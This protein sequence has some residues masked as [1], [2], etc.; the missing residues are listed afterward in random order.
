MDNKNQLFILA[1]NGSY[2]NRGCEGI[3]RGTVHILR[4]HFDDPRF[5]AVSSYKNEEQFKQQCLKETDT[6][7][8]HKKMWGPYKRLDLNWFLLQSLQVICPKA[9]KHITYKHLKPHLDEAKAVLALGGDHYSLYGT[10]LPRACTDLDDLVVAKGK[11]LVIWGAS[12][13]PFS[14]KPAYER[15]MINH[16]RK[17]YILARES[18]T[19]EY[20]ASKGLT[21][22]VYR[23]ADPAFLMKPTEPKKERGKLEIE[24][25]AIGLNLSPLMKRFVA[26]G[27]LKEWRG[28]S[29]DIISKIVQK[30]DRK[31]YL[32]PHVTGTPVND[33]YVF[34]KGVLS[35]IS[36]QKHR[37]IL[38]PPIYNASETKWIIS[39]MFVFAGARMHSTVASLSSCVPTLSFAYSIKA[40]GLNEDI[41]GHRRYCLSV[42]ELAPDIVAERIEE[43]LQESKSIR[44][45]L[46][47]RIPEVQDLAMDSGRILRKILQETSS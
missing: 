20:L 39:R 47:Q 8:T 25:G 38:I 21:E 11:P 29:A 26:N 7:I 31:I 16:L 4:N 34:L 37:I 43:L 9:I 42:D 3:T 30:T 10:S 27:N 44:K 13:G 24:D 33:D 12:V 15:Y 40:K 19:V 36:G 18:L 1:G 22:N 5:L 41:F 35:V 32:I 46:K 2:Y 28:I 23:V 45:H 6:S 17:V 14:K